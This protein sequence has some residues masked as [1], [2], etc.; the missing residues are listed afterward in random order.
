MD[1]DFIEV[2]ISGTSYY[3]SASDIPFIAYIDGNLV[4]TSSQ[5]SVTFKN[6]YS[7]ETTYPYINCRAQQ[8]CRYYPRYSSNY[9][10]V[11]DDIVINGDYLKT[12]N[13]PFLIF[14]VLFIL[15][16]VKLIW[17]R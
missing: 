14:C 7:D 8:V 5:F 6:S 15:L 12:A 2:S 10:V 16:G 17:K 13:Y 11:T 3:V 4:N 9:S 1:K